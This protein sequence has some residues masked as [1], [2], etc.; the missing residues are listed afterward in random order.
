MP[1]KMK[2]KPGVAQGILLLIGSCLPILASVLLGP[3]LADVQKYF[4]ATPGVKILTPVMLTISALTAALFAPFAG[5]LIDKIGRLRLLLGALVFYSMVGTAPLYLPTLQMIVFSRALLGAAE[6]LILT[7]CTTMIGDYFQG[8]E[9]AT[10]L[11]LQGAVTAFSAMIFFGAGG[12]LGE[13][14]WRTPFWLYMAGI[15]LVP[16]VFFLLWEPKIPKQDTSLKDHIKTRLPWPLLVAAY[17]FTIIT[18]VA[19]LMIPIQSSFLLNQLGLY[20]PAVAGSLSA[21]NS[22]AVFVG[23]LAFRF[24]LRFGYSVVF[25]VG[26]IF[27]GSG[28][29]IFSD[30]HAQTS[31]LIGSSISGFGIGILLVS[32]INWVLMAMPENMRGTGTGGFSACILIGQFISPL[33]ILLLRADGLSLSSAIYSFGLFVIVISILGYLAPRMIRGLMNLVA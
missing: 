31:L 7:I 9:R 5:I 24:I 11:S 12:A 23:A 15:V 1:M 8:K 18:G 4:V 21:A 20:S 10:W 25:A 16:L 14:G 29:L 13:L 26:F 28:M 30:S 6:A 3:V 22:A 32:L 19:L 17:P 33:V 27:C 2:A